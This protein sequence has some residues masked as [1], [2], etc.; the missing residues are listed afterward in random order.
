MEFFLLMQLFICS[1][2]QR[3]IGN[4][5]GGRERGE[6]RRQVEDAR[7]YRRIWPGWIHC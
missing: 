3:A 2:H 1:S 5:C 4:I 6:P 7:H